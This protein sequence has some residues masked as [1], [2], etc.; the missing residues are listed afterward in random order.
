MQLHH[1]GWAVNSLDDSLD[2]FQRQ[3]ALPYEGVEEFPT[4]RVAFFRAGAT[5]IELLEPTSPEDNVARFLADRGE[6]I[7]HCAYLVEDVASELIYA[8]ARG[9]RPIDLHPRRGARGSLIGFVDPGREDGVLVEY[10]QERP[11]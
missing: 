5:L 3:L 9:L 8:T 1:I 6:G 7:H 10:V 2:H 11:S 4:L